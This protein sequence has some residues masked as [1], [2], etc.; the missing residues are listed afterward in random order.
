MENPFLLPEDA[1]Q[2][3]INPIRD[4]IEQTA[5]YASRMTGKDYNLAVEHLRKKV[6]ENKVGAV[7]PTVVFYYRGDNGD[8][9]KQAAPLRAYLGNIVKNGHILAA[10]GTAYLHPTV[11]R[12]KIVGYLDENVALRKKYKKMAQA[13]EAEGNMAQYG[14]YNNAQD[15]AK[16]DNNSVSGGFVA[17]GSVIKNTS[18][19]STLTSTTRSIASLSNAC[20]ERLIEG[21]RHYYKPEIIVN[22]IASIATKT[23]YEEVKLAVDL[24]GLTIPSVDQVI[25]CI[26][27]SSDFYFRDTRKINKIK[28]LVEKMTDLERVAFV[29]T[30]DLYQI[31]Q[32]N[33]D[34]TR[35][36]IT[37]LSKRGDATPVEDVVSKL[38]KTDELVINYAHQVNITMLKGKGKDYDKLQSE[39]CFILYNTAMNI[40]EVI[41]F[42]K[43][44]LKAFFLTKNS[45]PTMASLPRMIRRSVVLSD[46]DS[47]MFSVD[48][49]VKW[50][51]KGELTFSDDGY[52]VAGSVMYM[53]TQSIAHILAH[54]SANMNVERSRLFSLAMKPEY[55]FPVF[56]QTSVAKHYYTAMMVKEGNVYK[57]IK[58]EIK[59]VHMKDS[60]LPRN[61]TKG[62]AELMEKIIR[63]VMNGEKLSVYDTLNAAMD[64]EREILD[65]LERGETTY[66]KRLQIKP[67]E[68]YKEKVDVKLN[69]EGKA[70]DHTN[71]RHYTCWEQCFAKHAKNCNS[72][73]PPPY[74]S[75]TIPLTLTNASSV[76]TWLN[77]LENKEFAES[78]R[79]WMDSN[80]MKVLT[81][82]HIPI[83]HCQNFGIPEELRPVLDRK[84]IVLALTK[85]YRNVLESLGLFSKPELMFVEQFSNIHQV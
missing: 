23:N 64:V 55:V 43:P 21:G 59:G 39:E 35:K 1:Y 72:Y 29:Y 36:F 20:N 61:I 7:D 10:T 53:A 32:L 57:D 67:K 25:K 34:F 71:Y 68:S 28:A 9:D 4:W 83:A 47:T 17:E 82:L 75:V 26:R 54:F 48:G 22:N 33:Q 62:A 73:E 80:C 15:N 12:S 37:N 69:A 49:W 18:A 2:R 52:A 30:G 46:T 66:L 51:F 85:S 31:R 40:I 60:T 42:Y 63:T 11:K 70:I 13:F 38:Y 6:Q 76:V 56:A 50:Y 14:Y 65:S 77:N 3:E 78:F 5:W 74:T 58:M 24:Y 27:R 84:R 81:Q 45:P 8:R 44:F 41:N 19:H 16:R 79:K